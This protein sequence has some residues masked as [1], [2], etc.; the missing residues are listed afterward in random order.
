MAFV[1]CETFKKSQEAQDNA[2]KELQNALENSE[3]ASVQTNNEQDQRLDNLETCCENNVITNSEQEQLLKQLATTV[4]GLSTQ[5]EQLNNKVKGGNQSLSIDDKG[6]KVRISELESNMLQLKED[7]LFISNNPNDYYQSFHIHAMQGSDE[8]GDGSKEKPFRTVGK[9]LAEMK[10]IPSYVD[11][12]LYK[13][14]RYEV[15][16]AYYN[17]FKEFCNINIH[18]YDESM[19]SG[20]GVMG[21]PYSITSNVYYRGYIAESYPRP[22]LVFPV[23]RDDKLRMMRRNAI[24]ANKVCAYGIAIIINDASPNDEMSYSGNYNGA[25]DCKDVIELLGCTVEWI[26]PTTI[27]S[28]VGAYRTDVLFRGNVRWVNSLLK[29]DL[30]VGRYTTGLISSS[31]S[32]KVSAIDWHG[33]NLNGYGES[34]DYPTLTRNFSGVTQNIKPNAISTSSGSSVVNGVVFNWDMNG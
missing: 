14:L 12:F 31:F 1:K 5:Q 23:S 16:D 21:Y 32:D 2:I 27:G 9:A 17:K 4:E 15:D 26:A 28:G 6:V 3:R 18:A 20:K 30:T 13:G 11:I 24:L 7:G 33:E 29:T 19:P 34:P 8:A 10:N 25:F 22:I